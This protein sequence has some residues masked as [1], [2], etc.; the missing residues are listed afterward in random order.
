MPN[1]NLKMKAMPMKHLT[2]MLA[3]GVMSWGL[4]ALG[5]PPGG[6]NP[7]MSQEE[8]DFAHMAK[9]GHLMAVMAISDAL[10][11]TDAETLKLS[12]TLKG[13]EERRRPV[14]QAMHE[15]MKAVRAAADGDATALAQVDANVQKVLDGRAQM[16][17]LDKELFQA[18]S[19]DL[20]PQKKAKL[21]RALAHLGRG[22]VGGP[23]GFGGPGAREGRHRM[24]MMGR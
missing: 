6:R 16:A 7:D 2:T 1:L 17:A 11:L 5:A 12:Q 23:G 9:R 4:T 24:M 15:A 21:G 20:S 3:V 19:K 10:E 14:R 22:G 18:L 13:L 8:P